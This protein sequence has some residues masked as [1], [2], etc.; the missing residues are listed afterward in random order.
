MESG[1]L[2]RAYSPDCFVQS[3]RQLVQQIKAADNEPELSRQLRLF[4]RREMQRIIWRDLNRLAD[5]EETTRDVTLL[6]EACIQV[7][8]DYLHPMVADSF[9]RP[10]DSQGREQ[11]LLVIAMGKMGGCE[12]SLHQ[13]LILSLP[14]QRR[15]KL[16]VKNAQS[17]INNFLSALDKS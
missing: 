7:A 2:H 16:R 5:L 17:P 14:T 4:R 13:I 6:A 10:L 11:K 3:L 1:D 9:G 15:V 8:L 12:L